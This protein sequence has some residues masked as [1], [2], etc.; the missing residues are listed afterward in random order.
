MDIKKV[1]AKARKNLK[2]NYLTPVLAII[3]YGIFMSMCFNTAKY[4]K[5]PS[6]SI[7]LTLIITSLFYMGL[8][9][10]IIKTAKGKKTTVDELF[11]RTDL[12]WRCAAITIVFLFINTICGLL[13]FTAV[14]SLLVFI[15]YQTDL[16]IVLSSLMIVIGFILSITIAAFWIM[17]MLDFSQ[18]YFILYDNEQMPLKE[19]LEKSMDI[20][21]GHKTEYIKL[22]LSFIG[23]FILGIFTFRILYFWLIP[24]IYVTQANFYEEIK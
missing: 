4:V 22:I 7:I 15:T 3:I 2:G 10:I 11:Q 23:W 19:I 16:N 6:L 17:L 14:N 12:F 18:S 20:M 13:E 9:Q 5:A 24:Y 21:E 1:K 8:L